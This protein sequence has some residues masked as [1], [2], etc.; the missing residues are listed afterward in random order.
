MP[1]PRTKYCPKCKKVKKRKEFNHA[2]GSRDSLQSYCKVCMLAV[3]R[4]WARNNRE[5]VNESA[6]ARFRKDR[7]KILAQKQRL[8]RLDHT[9]ALAWHEKAKA[10]GMKIVVSILG[11]RCT[12]PGCSASG[13]V[14]YHHIDPSTKVNA[15]SNMCCGPEGPLRAELLKCRALCRRHHMIAEEALGVFRYR[16]KTEEKEAA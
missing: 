16:R 15:I 7:K 11:D 12:W 2:G 10:R 13:R 9:A 14:D 3:G 5:K 6:R 8:Y 1:V 4:E